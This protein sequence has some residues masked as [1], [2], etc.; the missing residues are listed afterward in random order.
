ME[1]KVP[2]PSNPSKMYDD[3]KKYGLGNFTF[4]VIEE[5]NKKNLRAKELEYIRKLQPYYNYIGKHRTEEEKAVL[6]EA[7]KRQWENY[8]EEQKQK[9]YKNFK[10]PD[11]GHPVSKETRE[12]ISKKISEIQGIKVMIVESGEV[13]NK[14]KDAEKHLGVCSGTLTRYFKENKETVKGFHVVK[15]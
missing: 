4:E 14:M 6:R 8:T 9:I 2:N 7:G 5:C 10:R 13:F 11:F 15:V 1:H 12:K 3:I